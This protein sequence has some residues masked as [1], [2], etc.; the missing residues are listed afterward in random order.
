[1]IVRFGFPTF[2]YPEMMHHLYFT[3]RWH[4]GSKIP[5]KTPKNSKFQ[6]RLV[7]FGFSSFF[8]QESYIICI[9]HVQFTL[10]RKTQE[11]PPK[12][13]NFKKDQSDSDSPHF[14]PRN[15]ISFVFGIYNLLQFE[16]SRKDPPKFEI[17]TKTSQIRIPRG[18]FRGCQSRNHGNQDFS[19][20]CRFHVKVHISR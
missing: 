12:S 15:D 13:R 6:E 5:G 1:M 19:F 3:F 20:L 2:F 7:R 17:L 18:R 11:R 8:T 4:F 16:K 10:V 14:L 9:L